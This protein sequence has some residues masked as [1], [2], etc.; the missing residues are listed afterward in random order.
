MS[1][2]QLYVAADETL[3][4]YKMSDLGSPIAAYPLGGD[5]N[6]CIISDNRI[7]LGG[8]FGLLVFEKS[9]SIS[10]EPLTPV[11]T[12]KIK[13]NIIQILDLRH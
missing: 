7:Y 12:L 6:S 10:A 2:D 9:S 5:C 1:G 8:R 4:V 11:T 3:F 13:R